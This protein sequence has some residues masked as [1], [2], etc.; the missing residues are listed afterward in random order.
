[1]VD[2]IERF[3]PFF[4]DD[5][6]F[7]NIEK[8]T[9]ILDW[10]VETLKVFD[11]EWKD[12]FTELDINT[13]QDFAQFKEP[14]IIEN[15]ESEGINKAAMIAEMIFWQITRLAEK[16]EQKKKIMLIGLDNA[17]KTSTLTAL[18]EQYS[19]IK[20][21]LPTR[22]LVRQSMTVFGYEVMSFDMG[23]QAEYRDQYF[24]NADKY[25]EAADLLI[26]CIDIQDNNRY[27]ES[28]EYL[29]KVCETFEKFGFYPPILIVFTKMDPD[30]MNDVDLNKNRI[31]LI[32]KIETICPKFDV[33]YVNSSIFDRN[34]IENLFSF[35]LKRISTSNAV[36][37]ESIHQFIMDIEARS[38]CLISSGGLVYGSYGETKQEEEMLNNSASYLQNLYQFHVG[39]G[40]QREDSYLLNYK[41]NNLYFVAESITDSESGSV[42]L[43]ILTHD[44]EKEMLHIAHFKEELIPLIKIFL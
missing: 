8:L 5:A 25:F 24:E 19:S 2:Y 30:L 7:D 36:I 40:L 44:I 17:G 15:F 35:A 22:G 13:V 32:D 34:S 28:L 37:E 27:D 43:W 11:V 41:T 33:G 18:S 20:K 29:G 23:G 42:Y 14:I 1:M 4:K 10:P 3:K 39:Q 26:Y 21:L 38:C 12:G 9:D 16:G 31:A 6:D